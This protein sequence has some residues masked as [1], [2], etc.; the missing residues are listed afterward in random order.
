LGKHSTGQERRKAKRLNPSGGKMPVMA[1]CNQRIDAF[2]RFRSASCLVLSHCR[3]PCPVKS[4]SH[5]TGVNGNG[6]IVFLCVL[7]ASSEAPLGRDKRA[8]NIKS[9]TCIASWDLQHS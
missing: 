2:Y 8:V 7:C 9:H 1:P 4:E 5:L 6:I 3:R